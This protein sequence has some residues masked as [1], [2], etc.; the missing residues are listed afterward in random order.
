MATRRAPSR[1]ASRESRQP[2]SL[3]SL[4]D[5]RWIQ[6][7]DF[8]VTGLLNIAFAAGLWRA[9]RPGRGGTW[10]PLLIGAYGIGLVGAGVF[11]FEPS[12]GYPPGAPP[13]LLEDPGWSYALH[14]VAFG[15]VFV[16]L[17]AACF[18]FTRHFAARGERGWAFCC[19]ATGVALPALYLLAGLLSD[20]GEDS[21]P[22]SLLLRAMALLGWGRASVLAVR[23]R[24]S[25]TPA[26]SGIG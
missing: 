5:L 4:G 2:L 6:I 23:V 9:L 1:W 11:R 26:G 19:A 12:W 24:G 14:G 21:R 18:V 25:H 13:G 7:A 16:S 22:L 3:L 8:V 10:G 15:V 20:G 17:V